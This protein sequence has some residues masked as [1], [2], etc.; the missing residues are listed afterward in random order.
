MIRFIKG[1][2]MKKGF[3]LLELVLVIIIL[4]ILAT[5]ALNQYGK[6]IERSRAAEAKAILGDLRKYAV[7]YYMEYG[8]LTAI[9]PTNLYLGSTMD[10]I[11][12]NCRTSHYFTYSFSTGSVSSITSTATR[13]TS[14][15]KYP[16]GTQAWT[17]ILRSDLS[18]DT[19]TWA[20]TGGY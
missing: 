19:D 9:Q 8:T 15:G 3:T 12:T 16:Q 13:C 20:G 4:G 10:W 14:D 18:A 2:A 7:G 6:M 17:L 11:P 1:G 5:L